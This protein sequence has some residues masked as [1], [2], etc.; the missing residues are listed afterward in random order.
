MPMQQFLFRFVQIVVQC[1]SCGEVFGEVHCQVIEAVGVHT[2]RTV[3]K[4]SMGLMMTSIAFSSG[5][6]GLGC[7][8]HDL[9]F[10]GMVFFGHALQ[11]T[12]VLKSC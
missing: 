5:L 3:G 9:G 7:T 2:S 1:V 12:E 8:D 6:S 10:S 4:L 11:K